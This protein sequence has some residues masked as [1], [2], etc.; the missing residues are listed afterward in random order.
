MTPIDGSTAMAPHANIG[1]R[2]CRRR[3]RLGWVWL[4]IGVGAV[5]AMIIR[6]APLGWYGLTAFPFFMA[7]LGYFQA[8]EQTCVFFAAVQQRDMDGGAERITDA[9]EMA[10]VSE[11]ARTVWLR[12]LFGTAV[13]TAAALA[14]GALV[15]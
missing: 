1:P 11:H 13:L 6:E 10:R 12:S 3:G 4:G 8:R 5:V 2:G 14:V 9:A 7:T 15:R